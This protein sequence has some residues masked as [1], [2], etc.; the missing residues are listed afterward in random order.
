M[1]LRFSHYLIASL[2]AIVLHISVLLLLLNQPSQGALA[3]GEHGVEIGLGM[4]GDFGEKTEMT[5]T[6]P[7]APAPKPDKVLHKP[8]VLV[9]KPQVLE[10]KPEE[11]AEPE[12][13]QFE[14]DPPLQESD[15]VMAQKTP[16]SALLP[17]QEA[18]EDDTIL[19]DEVVADVQVVDMVDTD[20]VVT[21]IV[22]EALAE[23]SKQAQETQSKSQTKQT[24]GESNTSSNGG[25]AGID[26]SYLAKLAAILAQH[27][28]YPFSSRKKAEEGVAILDFEINRNGRVLL[29]QIQKS[30][31]FQALDK[32]VLVM[33]KRA[34][35]F[36]PVPPDIKGEPIRFTLPIA[37]KLNG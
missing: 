19:V 27:K 23:L 5:L 20:I 32:A 24:T 30:S 28:R 17:E 25:Q 8:E 31:G 9:Q 6:K 21:D 1:N 11:L 36:P 10:P 3:E 34:E 35:P 22:D 15:F 37:F 16:D 12:T 26:Q 29:S 18:S 33:L 7:E 4:L 2:L 14:L 13:E